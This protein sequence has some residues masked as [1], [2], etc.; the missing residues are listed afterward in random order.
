MLRRGL[1]PAD[2][3]A[4]IDTREQKPLTLDPLRTVKRGL[5]TADYSILG[6]EK[7]IAVERKSLPDLLACVGRERE[8]FDR[9]LDRLR[10]INARAVVVEASWEELAF[11]HNFGRSMITSEQVMGSVLG[12]MASGIP[13]LFVKNHEL[14]GQA[15]SRF[16]FIAA[17]RV[18]RDHTDYVESVLEKQKKAKDLGD[19]TNQAPC[20]NN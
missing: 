3:T 14:A 6:L 11:T 8:R 1:L 4:I 7:F 19:G 17:R 18:W 2:I 20:E 9:C 12:W 10:Q 13:F 16:L 5:D 15:V